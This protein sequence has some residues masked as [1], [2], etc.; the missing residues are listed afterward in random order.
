VHLVLLAMF[1]LSAGLSGILSSKT[2]A[3]L[4]PNIR[5]LLLALTLDFLLFGVL[6]GL[7]WLSS[8]ANADQLLLHWRGRGWPI[9]WGMI[10]SIALRFAVAIVII[11]AGAFW[12][13]LHGDGGNLNHM[14]PDMSRMIDLSALLNDPVYLAL[15]LTLVSFVVA[16]F[17]E[18]L[19]RAAMLAGIGALFPRALQSWRGRAAA[20]LVVAVIFGLG[21]TAQG[22]VGVGVTGLLGVGLGVIMLWHRSIWEA[23]IAHG[24]FDASTFALL[25]AV[26]KIFPGQ[27]PAH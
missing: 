27:F 25:Y 8:R 24:F 2:S 6:F 18:E 26:A 13:A 23:V 9:L 1:P 14:K 15:M 12:L 16:G 5:I 4:P 17:R 11:A 22:A 7:A 21:H 19:W 10:Y 20:I 3:A